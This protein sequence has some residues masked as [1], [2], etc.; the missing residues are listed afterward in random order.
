MKKIIVGVI[1][2]SV[3]AFAE[4]QKKITPLEDYMPKV[5]NP[6]IKTEE[7]KIVPWSEINKNK[8]E[9]K[10]NKENKKDI[11]GHFYI[12]YGKNFSGRENSR[13]TVNE[14]IINGNNNSKTY[15]SSSAV[16]GLFPYIASL[17]G[18]N[19]DSCLVR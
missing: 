7:Q 10:E 17:W 11:T 6:I 15:R 2:G 13:I 9:N 4:E 12:R 19:R 16:W 18:D 3:L 14:E 5:D 1:L 8:E